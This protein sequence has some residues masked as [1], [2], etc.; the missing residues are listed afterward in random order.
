[1]HAALPTSAQGGKRQ[2][3]A[4]GACP[5]NPNEG[6]ALP[7][8]THGSTPRDSIIARGC[9]GSQRVLPHPSGDSS[10]G[11][12]EYRL[13]SAA[14]PESPGF[15]EK[16]GLAAQPPPSSTASCAPRSPRSTRPGSRAQRIAACSRH[17][18]SRIVAQPGRRSIRSGRRRPSAPVEPA[19]LSPGARPP[20]GSMSST[21]APPVTRKRSTSP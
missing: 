9:R 1:M 14:P 5:A 19:P 21:P 13:S 7:A 20:S 15:R 8:R 2:Q 16:P 10:S 17:R 3:L 6:R 12:A 4:P 18:V 11:N